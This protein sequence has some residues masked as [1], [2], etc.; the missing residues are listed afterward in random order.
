MRNLFTLMMMCVSMSLSAQTRVFPVVKNYGGIFEVPDAVE[1][2]NPDLDYKIVIELA[3]GSEKPGE[4]N[5]SLNNIARMINLHAVGGVPKEKLHVV[6]AIHG[7]ASYS[8][9]NNDAYQHKYKTSNPNL[10]LYK[11]LSDAGVTFF[12]CGQSLIAREIDRT[13]MVPEVKIAT[14]MLTTLTTHQLMGYAVM[15]F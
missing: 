14:S 12:I 13:K 8:V 4:F 15:K 7:E 3:T 2:P 10:N 1:K 6:V 11:E 9:L 5:A